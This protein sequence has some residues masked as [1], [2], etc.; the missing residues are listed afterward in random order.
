MHKVQRRSPGRLLCLHLKDNLSIEKLLKENQGHV[1]PL[2]YFHYMLLKSL[3]NITSLLVIYHS[4]LEP[5]SFANKTAFKLVHNVQS[6]LDN[7]LIKT[8]KSG[9][10]PYLFQKWLSKK[11]IWSLWPRVGV[12]SLQIGWNFS[13]EMFSSWI[14]NSDDRSTSF[15]PL[16]GCQPNKL[17]GFSDEINFKLMPRSES[18]APIFIS[19]FKNLPFFIGP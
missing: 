14:L 15:W 5:S 10:Y 11:F 17:K 2:W 13:P 19:T 8:V 1:A 4:A 12:C 7:C 9:D 16:L 6:V 3:W 18:S